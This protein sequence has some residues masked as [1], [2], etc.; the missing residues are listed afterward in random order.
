MKDS[1]G[2][3]KFQDKGDIFQGVMLTTANIPT[4]HIEHIANMHKA[5]Q[6]WLWTSGNVFIEI[7]IDPLIAPSSD[8][9]HEIAVVQRCGVW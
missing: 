9:N 2:L 3:V 5:I 8:P 7:L 4:S 1:D 6:A